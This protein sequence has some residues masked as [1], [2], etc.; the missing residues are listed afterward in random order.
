MTEPTVERRD[1]RYEIRVEAE[2]AGAAYY[3]DRGNQRIFHHTEIDPAFQG[4]GLSSTL[5]RAALDDTR[6]ASLRVVPVCPAVSRYV[7]KHN[8]FD[9]ITDPVSSDVLTWLDAALARNAGER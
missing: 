7:K 6:A 1:R 3:V 2:V 8:S 9:D 5:I 4:Q